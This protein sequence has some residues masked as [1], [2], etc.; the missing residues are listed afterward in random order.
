ALANGRVY[1]GYG[2]Y[3]G[4]C[5]PYHGWLVS[6]T[7][8][9]TAKLA[10]DVTPHTGQGAIW[11]PGGPA[12]DASGNVYVATGNPNPI[13][14]TGDYGESVLKLDATLHL[15]HNFSA[16]NANDDQDL[17]SVGPAILGSNLVFQTGKQH[18]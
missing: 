3:S 8:A 15:L 17:G 5:G 6:L 10:F 12:I 9:G 7:Q 14:N 1:V 13:V 4:D 18:V 11:A 2:G 16:S